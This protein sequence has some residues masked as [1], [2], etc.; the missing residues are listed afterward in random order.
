MDRDLTMLIRRYLEGSAT[1]GD[2]DELERRVVASSSARFELLEEAALD[3]GLRSSF[4][5][6]PHPVTAAES[7]RSGAGARLANRLAWVAAA[8]ILVALAGGWTLYLAYLAPARHSESPSVARKSGDAQAVRGSSCESPLA[9]LVQLRGKVAVLPQGRGTAGVE[10]EPATVCSGDVLELGRGARVRVQYKDGSI[11]LIRGPAR[12]GLD[13]SP[14]GLTVQ[15]DEGV[16]DATISRQADGCPM[17]VYT[18]RMTV[19]VVGTEFRVIEDPAAS[20]VAVKSGR[21]E[22]FR[23]SDGRLIPLGMGHYATV[24]PRVLFGAIPVGCP[25]WRGQCKAS[26]GDQYP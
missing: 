18:G 16:V 23:N 2:M 24:N 19:R 7:R 20:W 13:G 17:V 1:A 9:T 6:Q 26:V 25:I 8:A 4:G 10:R 22:V 21:V 11:L 15:V 14:A 12:V 3:V 5:G